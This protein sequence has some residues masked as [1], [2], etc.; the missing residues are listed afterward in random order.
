ML[1]WSKLTGLPP[2]RDFYH[3]EAVGDGV[4]KGDWEE[5]EKGLGR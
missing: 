3:R 5:V 4:R 1:S 2:Q